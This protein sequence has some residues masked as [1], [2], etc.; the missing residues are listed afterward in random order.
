MERAR[1]KLPIGVG[2]ISV[3]GD[4]GG[5]S[6]AV[7]HGR[8]SAERDLS[9]SWDLLDRRIKRPLER[10][11]GVAQVDL[12]GVEPQEVRID[13]DL[14]ALKRHGVQP[15]DLVERLNAANLD[16]DLGT[17]HSDILLYNVRSKSRFNDI[18]TIRNLPL[19]TEGLKVR[20]VANVEMRE[21]RLAYGRH[22]DRNFAVGIDVNK[23]STAN[24]VE[25]ADRLMER[26][27]EIRK[28]P[29]L[30]GI[31]LLIWLNSGE[32]IRRS[33]AGL[34]NAG[35]FGGL[36]AVVVLFL[37]LRRI[38]TT[39][40]VAVSIPFSLVVTCGFMYLT[41]LQFNVLTMT[42]LMLG[43]GMLV[44]NAV[45]VTENIHRLEG[46]GKRP[47]EAARLGTRQV[48]L[49]VLAATATTVIVWSW[50]FVIEKREMVIYMGET[51]IPICIS[52][53]C[54][55]LISL[56]FIPMATARLSPG[57]EVSAGFVL[58]RLLPAYR[59]LL[60]WTMRHRFITLFALLGLAGT[61]AIPIIRIE[62]TGDPRFRQREVALVYDIHDTGSKEKIEVYVNKI[63]EWLDS[64]K[65][66]LKLEHVYSIFQ[67]PNYAMTRVY[68]Q[69]DETTEE[70][71]NR[72][73]QKLREGL[74]KI[75]GVTVQVGERQWWR[76]ERRGRKIVS[77]AIHGEDPEYLEKV[78]INIEEKLRGVENAIDVYGPSVRGQKEVRI[79]VDPER[80]RALD[81]TPRDVARVV[82][83]AYRGQRLR[84]YEGPNG[85]IE[86]IC[87][88]PEQ[89][90]PGLASLD[91]LTI[92]RQGQAPVPLG[93]VADVQIARTPPHISRIDRKTTM[94]VAVEFEEEGFNTT[95]GREA[96]DARLAGFTLP[97][98]YTWDWGFQGRRHDEDLMIMVYGVLMALAV[99]VLLMMGLF[100]SFSQPIAILITLPLAFFGAFWILWLIG[101]QL[102]AV[103]FMG[104]IVLIGIVVN[105]GIVMVDHVNALRRN[106][107]DR[108]PALLQGCS[109]R[110]RP[111]LMT[112]V[113]TIFGLMPL[114]FSA[115]TVAN[116]YIDSLAVAV[117][118]G[119][120]TSTI[121]TLIALPVWYTTVEDAGTILRRF[122]PSRAGRPGRSL[123]PKGGVLVDKNKK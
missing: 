31:R 122:L 63:E 52:V 50:L 86:V 104:V 116:A 22:L 97:E 77:V 58:R 121:F 29:E 119:L 48:A 115:A 51:A 36:L 53:C 113:T 85:E 11:K 59:K 20:D 56:T 109:D 112:A 107:T 114:A 3:R 15:A 117:I 23:E 62:K 34:R 12:Y 78:A 10:I 73:R 70:G 43:V 106:G 37:F 33:I 45:V 8:I 9:E 27:E 68:L 60:A 28:D 101:F 55:L 79:H 105:N 111:V 24:T 57:K 84:R 83:F 30:K 102:D 96:I 13:L 110:L 47:R 94:W 123:F 1:D 41:G 93:T 108:I 76:H 54:S 46:M 74:P 80:A 120:T 21:P 7:L 100:E 88:L 2:H 40:I 18:E 92:P 67:E 66:E 72:L 6:G 69:R 38:R 16:M 71:V 91:D 42:G 89:A 32:E 26:I 17:I 98:G 87:S 61:A 5:P 19:G 64:R 65:D 49:A 103:A 82:A 14:A 118:G 75:P 25:L 95:T 39:L 99:V 4:I 35:A 81:V 90:R 44:D